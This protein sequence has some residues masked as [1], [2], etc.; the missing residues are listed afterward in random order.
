MRQDDNQKETRKKTSFVDKLHKLTRMSHLIVL[1]GV[2][3][4]IFIAALF[5]YYQQPAR[6][7]ELKVELLSLQRIIEKPSTQKEVLEAELNKVEAELEA[8]KESFPQL[9]Q[10]VY[11]V[12]VL[13]ELAESNDIVTIF[14]QSLFI[15]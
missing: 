7:A 15:F 4:V 2:F 5:F 3:L 14:I 8:A 11:I 13:Y 12:D 9:E 1:C 10:S 6:Q